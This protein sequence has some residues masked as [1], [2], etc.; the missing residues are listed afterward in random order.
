M[1]AARLLGVFPGGPRRGV[2]GAGPPRRIRRMEDVAA[3][4]LVVHRRRAVARRRRRWILGSLAAICL[5]GVAGYV[6]GHESRPTAEGLSRQ[7]AAQ[8]TMDKLISREVN[9]TLLELWKME[10]VERIR[11]VGGI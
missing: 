9:R 6:L 5:A 8:A 2:E 10:D 7:G 11:P 1:M 4:A 3:E